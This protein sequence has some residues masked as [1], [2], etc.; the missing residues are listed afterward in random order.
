MNG[1]RRFEKCFRVIIAADAVIPAV[2]VGGDPVAAKIAGIMGTEAETGKRQRAV[3]QCAGTCE[4]A[5]SQYTYVGP[6]SCLLAKNHPNGGAKTCAYGCIGFGDCQKAC[7]FDAI[8][9]VDG[10]AV[11]D[12]ELCKACGKCVAAC[13]N[14]L[15]RLIPYEAEHIVVCSS[16]EKGVE[17]KKACKAGCIGCGLCAKN[18]PQNAIQVEDNVARI[19][20]DLCNHCGTCKEKCPVKIIS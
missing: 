20:Y 6:Q 3:V 19:D 15:I 5:G 18:C 4:A 7:P 11:V 13:P 17:V 16:K 14:H 2:T 1:K 8:H 10:I 12:K 9:I